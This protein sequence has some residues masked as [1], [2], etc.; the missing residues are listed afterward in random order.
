M[1]TLSESRRVVAVMLAR[2]EMINNNSQTSNLTQNTNRASDCGITKSMKAAKA[3]QLMYL[4]TMKEDSCRVKAWKSSS[5]PIRQ[6]LKMVLRRP[7]A[8][9]FKNW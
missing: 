7:S 3:S 8:Q 6:S 9:E 2:T 5:T 4:C 1:M